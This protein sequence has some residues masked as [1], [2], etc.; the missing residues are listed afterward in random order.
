MND[1]NLEKVLR[2]VAVEEIAVPADLAHTTSE[3]LKSGDSGVKKAF[4][5]IVALVFLVNIM[6]SVLFGGILFLMRPITLV[7]W[8]IIGSIY[9]TVNVF[10]YTLTFI[11]F[12]KLQDMLKAY[13]KGG[14]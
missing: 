1:K 5:Y 11:Y 14:I 12:G 8:I 10:L 4:P 13:S 6:I 2:S 3:L 7:E 9:S